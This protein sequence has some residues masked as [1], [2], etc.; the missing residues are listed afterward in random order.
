MIKGFI[1]GRT[2][3]LALVLSLL[4]SAA[5]CRDSGAESGL[6]LGVEIPADQ[7]VVELA[8][9]LEKPTDYNGRKIVMNGVISGQCASLCEFFLLDGAH[10]VT[11]YS[12]GFSF[13]KL[14]RG[15]NVTI[16]ALVTSGDENVVF[17]A[18]GLSME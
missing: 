14:D 15:K 11:V 12:Q 16:Y 7:P 2:G 5:G 10:T 17:S 18:L 9:V 4:L 1:K 8:S 3:E 6:R 13:P